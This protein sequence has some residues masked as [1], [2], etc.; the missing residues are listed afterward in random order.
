MFKW[1]S[2]KIEMRRAYWD[3]YCNRPQCHDC[4]STWGTKEYQ[5]YPGIMLCPGC[6]R[7]REID[8]DWRSGIEWDERR[9]EEDANCVASKVIEKLKNMNEG[10]L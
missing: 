3:E 4:V 9:K 2:K 5:E 10:N 8:E 6:Y 7:E 1:L